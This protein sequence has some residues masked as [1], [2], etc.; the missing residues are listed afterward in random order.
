[1]PARR[2]DACSRRRPSSL[3]PVGSSWLRGANGQGKTTLLRTLAGLPRPRPHLIAWRESRRGAAGLPRRCQRAQTISLRG[4]RCASCFISAAA[5]SRPAPSTRRSSASAWPAA[6]PR[7][8]R[9]LSQGQRR[10]VALARLAA[11]SEAAPACSTSPSPMLH[12]S[13]VALL[14]EVI[15]AHARRTAE[16][17]PR[18]ATC[19]L[20]IDDPAPT[21]VQLHEPAFACSSP[22]RPRANTGVRSTKAFRSAARSP[23]SSRATCAWPRGAASTPALPLAFFTV[24]VSLFPLGVGPEPQMLRQIAPGVVWVAALV[25]AMLSVTSSTPPT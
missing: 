18:P 1:M 16:G 22:G 6:A 24:A 7:S 12:A 8:F 9:T 17:P 13:G 19:P 3:A 25:A 15:V 2:A 10:R 20:P 4:S 5:S 21:I 11:Q 14:A 23:C